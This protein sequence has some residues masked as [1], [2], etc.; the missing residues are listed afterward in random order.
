MH[1]HLA[2]DGSERDPGHMARNTAFWKAA[3][4][5]TGTVCERQIIQ[6]AVEVRWKISGIDVQGCPL[7][8]CP[9]HKAED[10]ALS[11]GPYHSSAGQDRFLN[12]VEE[13]MI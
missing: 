13:S 10:S 11:F 2:L 7:W 9:G 5:S 12:H 6:V 4:S 3:P 8:M 1:R